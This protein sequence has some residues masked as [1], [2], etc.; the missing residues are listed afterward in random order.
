MYNENFLGTSDVSILK[1]YYASFK[2]QQGKGN[3]SDVGEFL[4]ICTDTAASTSKIAKILELFPLVPAGYSTELKRIAKFI[5][6]RR[7]DVEALF[8]RDNVPAKSFEE[9]LYG[10]DKAQVTPTLSKDEKLA[11]VR[12]YIIVCNSKR[13]IK[14]L[15]DRI[16]GYLLKSEVLGVH[17]PSEREKAWENFV[18][19]G[20]KPSNPKFLGKPNDNRN[21]TGRNYTTLIKDLKKIH[22]FFDNLQFD[23]V[24]K[25]VKIDLQELAQLTSKK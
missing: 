7:M 13:G 10:T 17:S 16:F 19:K 12:D 20:I 8:L 21:E 23:E 9:L 6:L 1:F 22:S 25:G 2:I 14:Q 3:V 15:G 24:A 4:D 5:T 11:K 18:G